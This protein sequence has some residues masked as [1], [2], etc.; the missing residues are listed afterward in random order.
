MNAYIIPGLDMQ[1]AIRA[2]I[3]CIIEDYYRMPRCTLWQSTRKEKIVVARQIAMY[4]MRKYTR[5]T[6][7]EIGVYFRRD[8]STVVYA[9]RMV[10]F[11]AKL[12]VFCCFY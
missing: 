6:L 7:H 8:H 5:K 4:F 2:D 9:C 3:H 10:I 11:S 12:A 1:N